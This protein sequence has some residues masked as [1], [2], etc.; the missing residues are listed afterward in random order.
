MHL[1][2]TRWTRNANDNA[3]CIN[4]KYQCAA[5]QLYTYLC[6]YRM[7]RVFCTY[8]CEC[9]VRKLVEFVGNFDQILG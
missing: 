7:Q 4:Y 2:L 8:I 3:H 6:K 1:G 5:M 9:D